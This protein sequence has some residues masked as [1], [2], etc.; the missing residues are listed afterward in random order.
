MQPRL[1]FRTHYQVDEPAFLRLIVHRCSSP[2]RSRYDESVEVALTREVTKRTKEFNNAAAGYAVDLAHGLDVLTEQNVWTPKG[3]LLSIF[4]A[5]RNGDWE[6]E[7]TLDERERLGYLR[8]FLEG[9]GAALLFLA[10][11]VVNH[12]AVPNSDGDWNRLAEQMIVEIYKEYLELTTA[13]G[14]RVALRHEIDRVSKG[15]QG[16]S[17]SHKLF[18]HLQAM[19]RIGLL[20][21]S[22][23]ATRRYIAPTSVS[24]S[25][26]EAL[27]AEVP[28]AYAL[29]Q[30]AK[31]G[32]WIDVA[33]RVLGHRLVSDVKDHDG[34]WSVLS[35]AYRDIMST[36]VPLCPLSTLVEA[37]QLDERQDGVP[38]RDTVIEE[39]ESAQRK[40]SRD[41][42]FHVDR[43]GRPAFIRL[44]DEFVARHLAPAH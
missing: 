24:P 31:D 14:D 19:Y 29:E 27:V 10:R 8:I 22:S 34:F 35:A 23:L 1:V 20:A 5:P 39:I 6:A 36:G 32:R 12:G 13:P 26:L 2:V 3:H 33:A 25:P 30:V 16:K 41:I 15:Y 43:R 44:S 4:S 42:R 37:L 7:L 17:G 21:R 40:A 18:I 11:R 28:N 9:D 38:T